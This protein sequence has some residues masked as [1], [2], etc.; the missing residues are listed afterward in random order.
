M[1]TCFK[2]Q[3]TRKIEIEKCSCGETKVSNKP[4]AKNLMKALIKK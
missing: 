3:K 1:K 4:N 2:C